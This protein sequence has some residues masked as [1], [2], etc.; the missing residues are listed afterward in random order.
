MVRVYQINGFS[1]NGIWASE[2]NF[3]T[4]IYTLSNHIMSIYKIFENIL[5]LLV[6]SSEMYLFNFCIFYM[7]SIYN[8]KFLQIIVARILR[9]Y[10]N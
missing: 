4:T 3:S 9:D 7:T 10:S 2:I 1:L 5:P 6:T 8:E